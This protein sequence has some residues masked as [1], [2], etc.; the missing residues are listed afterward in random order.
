MAMALAGFGCHLTVLSVILIQGNFTA[1][2][3]NLTLE[4]WAKFI[5]CPRKGKST[6]E[7]KGDW[8]KTY[9]TTSLSASYG[10]KRF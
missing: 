1:E 3:T 9:K 5:K 4:E 10:I 6:I 8:Q 2:V 7:C